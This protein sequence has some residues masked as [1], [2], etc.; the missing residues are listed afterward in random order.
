MLTK[1]IVFEYNLNLKLSNSSMRH[2][3]LAWS[4][5]LLH[6][7]LVAG[8]GAHL[9]PTTELTSPSPP[10]GGGE[11]EAIASTIQYADFAVWQRRWLE[12][13]VRE[14]QLEYW[15][16]ALAG[17]PPVEPLEFVRRLEGR[18]DQDQASPLRRRSF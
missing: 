5:H 12:G 11:G 6:D 8:Y 7:E 17:A 9:G 10:T 13:P 18:I 15:R 4:M 16:G 1:I 14:R 2:A 3:S